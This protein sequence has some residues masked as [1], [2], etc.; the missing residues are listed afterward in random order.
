MPLV[1]AWLLLVLWS[2]AGSAG[3]AAP[4]ERFRD[5]PLC[6]EMVVVAAGNFTMGSP[7]RASEWPPRLVTIKAPF[8]IGVYEVTVAEWA[9]CVADGGCLDREAGLVGSGADR[10]KGSLSWHDAKL[11]ANWLSRR[12]GKPYRL[13]SEAEWEYAARGGTSSTFWWGAEL[14]QGH[15]HC[16]TCASGFDIKGSVPVGSLAPNP[17]GLH[18]VSG[19]LW[20]WVE[21]CWRFGYDQRLHD[22][23]PYLTKNCRNRVLRGGGF[24]DGAHMMAVTTRLGLAAGNSAASNGVRIARDVR[25]GEISK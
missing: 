21:D 22:G 18:E 19:N 8:A 17:F 12:T 2:D 4:G 1:A 24:E 7:V 25:A 9:A 13:P 14:G 10:P 3:A 11:Y 6:P 15:A 5:C 20:E 23:A 16:R